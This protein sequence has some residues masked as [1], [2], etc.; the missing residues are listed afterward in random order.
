MI[1]ATEFSPPLL[2]QEVA[3]PALIGGYW[4]SDGC[5]SSQGGVWFKRQFQI[6]SGDKLWTGRWDYYDDPHCMVFLYAII[7]AGSYTQRPGKHHGE[8]N[9]D[10]FFDYFRDSNASQ[11]LFKRSVAD[12]PVTGIARRKKNILY[13]I[14]R[15]SRKISAR[16]KKSK[17]QKRSLSDSYSDQLYE[18]YNAQSSTSQSRF[19]AMLRGHQ[20]YEITTKKPPSTPSGTTEL[21]LHIA[22][23]TLISGTVVSA[24]RCDID[25]P[26]VPL[27]NWSRT[28]IPHAIEAPSTLKL[29]AKLGV[30]WNGQYILR[31]GSRDDNVWNA[32]LR[33]CAQIPPY[34]PVL[35]TQL[36][37]SFI[38]RFGLF[39]SATV[40]AASIWL[41]VPQIL[42]WIV[43]DLTR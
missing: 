2:H 7:A 17:K 19:A 15:L 43:Y 24:R 14:A 39:S 9:R 21:D 20:T 30:N 6:Y 37:S 25:Q 18:S 11:K 33:Q 23:S 36:R 12:N 35:R 29:R 8:I 13:K 38:L 42:L 10:T 3:L 41:F 31:L 27:I 28:C 16:D 1:R 5:E 40:T 22:E 26:G 34:N 32:P 4:H